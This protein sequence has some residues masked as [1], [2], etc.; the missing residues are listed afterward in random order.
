MKRRKN[1]CL[2][3]MLLALALSATAHADAPAEVPTTQYVTS[4]KGS[5][6]LSGSIY[7]FGYEPAMAG[8]ENSF[9]LYAFILNIDAESADKKNGLHSQLRYRDTKLRSYFLS[10][11]WF[12]EL[13]AYHRTEYGDLHVGKFYRN[14]GL[15]WDDSF[16]G[17]VQ[18]FNGLKLNPAYG[19]ELVGTRPLMDSWTVDYSAQFFPNNSTTGGSL[20]GRS[21]ESDPLAKQK[22]IATARIAPKWSFGEKNSLAFGI[23]GMRSS[24]QRSTSA[25]GNFGLSQEAADLTLTYGP[26]VTYVEVMNQNGERDDAAHPLGRPGYDTAVYLLAGTRWQVHPRVNARFNYSSANYVGQNAREEEF[27]PGLVF[28]LA[29]NLSLITE[30]D[31]WRLQARNGGAQT[32]LDRS[33]NTVLNYRF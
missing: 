5:L 28:T 21:V 27:V 30:F 24:L 32:L 3:G 13:Y 25:A 31:Y 33:Y 29:Q 4:S 9:D 17:N 6:S 19:V 23:S 26:S 22:N 20:P 7:L 16:F 8:A 2:T 18:Y 10:N 11:V 12:Q 14:V 15:L 1:G